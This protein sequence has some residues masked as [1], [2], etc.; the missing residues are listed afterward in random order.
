M[1]LTAR[2]ACFRA[3]AVTLLLSLGSFAHAQGIPS[4]VRD[5]ATQP[6]PTSQLRDAPTSAALTIGGW[7][8]FAAETEESGTEL[9]KTDGTPAGTQLV[10]DIWTGTTDS[11]PRSFVELG[12][13]LYFAAT[14]P[15]DGRELWRSDGTTSGTYRVRDIAIGVDD[16]SPARLTVAGGMIYFSAW[17][18]ATGRELWRSDGTALGTALVVDANVGPSDSM[19]P[20]FPIVPGV[21]SAFGTSFSA[22]LWV[23]NDGV[24]GEEVWE[25][26]ALNTG[27]LQDIRPGSSGSSPRDLTSRSGHVLFSADDGTT[28]REPYH[29]FGGS[30][31]RIGDL[32]PGLASSAP[33]NFAAGT[34]N[35]VV[36]FYFAAF[37]AA[38]G[39]ELWLYDTGSGAT[40]FVA[41]VNPGTASSDPVP[42]VSAT[43]VLFSAETSPE[44]RELWKTNGTT[45]G[46]VLVR[47]IHGRGSSSPEGFFQI[48]SVPL[49]VLFRATASGSDTELW[50]TDGT[51]AGTQ[52]VLDLRVGSEGSTPDI[53]TLLSNQRALFTAND[54]L[55]TTFHHTNGTAGGTAMLLPPP[56]GSASSDPLVFENSFPGVGLVCAADDGVVG[57]EPWRSDGS[58]AGTQLVADVFPG[59]GEALTWDAE[60]VTLEALTIFR[61]LDGVHGAEPWVSDG[62]PSGTLLL[63]DIFLGA[64]GSSPYGFTVMDGYV[65][66]F[67]ND[68]QY[69][70]ELWRTDGTPSG[71]MLVKDIQAGAGSSVPFNQGKIGKSG[72]LFFFVAEAPGLGLEPHVSDG[73]S[74][75]TQLLTDLNPGSASSMSSFVHYSVDTPQ[76]IFFNALHANHGVELWRS[77]GTPQTTQLALDLSPGTSNTVFRGLAY[78]EGLFVAA[79]T[80]NGNGLFR[81]NASGSTA[82]LLRSFPAPFG[83]LMVDGLTTLGSQLLFAGADTADGWE[84]WI[85]DGTSTGTQRLRPIGPG[86]SSGLPVRPTLF[87]DDFDGWFYVA[88]GSSTAL[89]SAS[90]GPE[91]FELWRTDGTTV[92]TTLHAEIAPGPSSSSPGRPALA[93]DMLYLS[94][95]EPA[96]GRELYALTPPAVTSFYLRGCG[97]TNGMVPCFRV[98]GAPYLGNPSYALVVEQARPASVVALH[99]GFGA[100]NVPLGG[101]CSVA[102]DLLLPYA[103]FSAASDR[104]GEATFS[105]P[106][107]SDP[108]LDGLEFFAQAYVVDPQGAFAGLLAFTGGARAIVR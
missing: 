39:N 57:S 94:A 38:Q 58:S 81:L 89:F 14:S 2:G 76:G 42:Y 50:V 37:R 36:K 68:E 73:T 21:R 106:L 23:A 12:G 107:P 10:R 79:I 101:G 35:R 96:T 55:G 66:F 15:V 52:Q 1:I 8:Y 44:G 47:D 20:S 51:N 54:G 86:A 59:P 71:T 34:F 46:T 90:E 28:G 4:L 29:S 105:L 72:G 65:L 91:G 69:G 84:P 61:A 22:V 60:A 5:I 80:T 74:A 87:G 102:V 99:V 78:A 7:T 103:P 24:H 25:T 64:T 3:L 11:N 41:D 83:L 6:S 53:L 85:S 77:Q 18:P 97:G 108:L 62:T 17:H 26:S 67:A 93:G 88:P 16:S 92:G 63:A 75:G 27:L 56:S 19:L 104:R 31:T 49:Q 48:S 98:I 13:I 33:Q 82:V 43:T 40:T 30:T 95:Y 9:W 70:R 45:A 32:N 100:W